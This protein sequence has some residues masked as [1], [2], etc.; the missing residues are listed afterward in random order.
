MSL[1]TVKGAVFAVFESIPIGAEGDGQRAMH[2]N[3]IG[4]LR[5]GKLATGDTVSI[6]M[7]DG[8]RA[9]A[10]LQAI[11]LPFEWSKANGVSPFPLE[12]RIDDIEGQSIVLSVRLPPGQAQDVRLDPVG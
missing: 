1:S 4:E 3:L 7:K 12:I 5:K 6:Q 10:K 2:T 9:S 11:Q 8:K